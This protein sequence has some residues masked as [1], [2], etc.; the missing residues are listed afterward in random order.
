MLGVE[1]E[2][3][4]PA[5]GIVHQKER[6]NN[7]DA[8][9]CEKNSHHARFPNQDMFAHHHGSFPENLTNPIQDNR[10]QQLLLLLQRC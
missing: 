8:H 6:Q 5:E 10:S 9:E 4:S 1:V 3:V 7:A 2:T